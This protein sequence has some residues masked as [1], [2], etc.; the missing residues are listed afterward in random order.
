MVFVCDS[1]EEKQINFSGK[2][3]CIGNDTIWRI[4]DRE[5]KKYK[6][7]K[8]VIRSTK[9]ELHLLSSAYCENPELKK[10]KLLLQEFQ[11]YDDKDLCMKLMQLHKS[12]AERLP[13]ISNFYSFVFSTIGSVECVMD[14]GCGFNPFSISWMRLKTE[15]CRYY[16]SDINTEII[17]IINGYFRLIGK[18]FCAKYEDV[19]IKIPDEEVNVAY[20]FKLLPLLERQKK[21]LALDVL[22]K[23]NAEYKVV[24]FPIKS[25]TGKSKGMED[26]YYEW[27]SSLIKGRFIIVDQEIVGNE[28]VFIVH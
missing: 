14:I 24:T 18:G 1:R 2:Y 26:F 23:L 15:S 3:E 7:E 5:K 21:G 9:S 6:K 22:C 4:Y 19:A 13:F 16:A 20:L 8:D 25:L 27:F 12:T 11:R 28:I 10:A 17:S